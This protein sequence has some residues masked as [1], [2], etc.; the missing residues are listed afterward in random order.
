MA[1][2]KLFSL[3]YLSAATRPF[4]QLDLLQLLTKSRENNSGLGVTGMLLF[5]DGNFLQVLEGEESKVQALY[6]KIAQDRRHR[7]LITL[8]MGYSPERDFP[9]WSMGF[10]DLRSS[11]LAKTPGFTRFLETSLTSSDFI[12]DPGKAKKLLLLFKE[13]KLI[14]RGAAL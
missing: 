9:D 13:E 12:S 5:K 2:S 8:S 7:T 1:D 10:N 14:S 11:E 6:E 4:S 3:I